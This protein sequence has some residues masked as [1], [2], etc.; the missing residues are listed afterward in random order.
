MALL[1]FS[2]CGNDQGNLFHVDI[3]DPLDEGSDISLIQVS[4]G[5]FL[6]G[7]ALLPAYTIITSPDGTQYLSYNPERPVHSVTVQGFKIST[8]EITQE[9]YKAVMGV[10][11]SKYSGMIDLPAE[12]V[13][14]EQAAS[15]CNKLSEISGLDRCYSLVNWECDFS[16]SGYRL[17]TEAE[18]EFACRAGIPGE[19]GSAASPEDLT[20]IAWFSANSGSS[21]HQAATLSANAAGLFDMQGNVW[22]WCND[23]YGFYNCNSQTDPLGAAN[24]QFRI[25]RGG[26]WASTADDLRAAARKALD[27]KLGNY[28]VGFRIVRR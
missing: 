20:R 1:L 28:T 22:E 11:P 21:P 23:R 18:W 27:P 14:W 24:G 12:Q 6:M 3:V 16:R 10:N 4:G 8:R 19:Y 17:P 13:S 9:Q 7:S 25:A 15:F 5:S 26:S 2:S